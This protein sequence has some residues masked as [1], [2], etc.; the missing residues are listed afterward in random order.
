[1]ARRKKEKYRYEHAYLIKVFAYVNPVQGSK[2][3]ENA[4]WYREAKIVE[5]GY[6]YVIALKKGFRVK[7]SIMVYQ[8]H[9]VKE[10]AIPRLLDYI[11]YNRNSKVTYQGWFHHLNIYGGITGK[12]IRQQKIDFEI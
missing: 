11:K 3:N 7:Y 9:N 8:F 4:S 1:M 12:F 2:V 6:G 5:T 10:A